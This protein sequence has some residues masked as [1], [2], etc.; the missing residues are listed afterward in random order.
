[1]NRLVPKRL[2]MAGLLLLLPAIVQGQQTQ[3]PPTAV[4]VSGPELG[5]MAPEFTLAWATRDSI[6]PAG[7]PYRLAHR[8]GKIVVLAF[9]PRDFT[10]G[11]TAELRTFGDQYETMFGKDVEVVAVS[12]DSLETHVR[13]A[14]SLK[15]PFSLLSDPTQAVAKMYGSNGSEGSMRRTVYVIDRDGRVFYRNL[16]FGAL[17]PK[18]Y[19]ELKAAIR[20]A[21]GS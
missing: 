1:M 7:S 5:E 8:R 13:F 10:T 19:D 15:L 16:R 3:G 17:D 21:R 14:S 20:E 9:Y 2:I 6:G 11:C 12:V 4:L 18:A